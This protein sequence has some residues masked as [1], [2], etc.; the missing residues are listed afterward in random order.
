[1]YVDIIQ[2]DAELCGDR[3]LQNIETEVTSCVR[4]R[5]DKFREH[6]SSHHLV[7]STREDKVHIDLDF[8]DSHSTFPREYRNSDDTR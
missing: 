3:R 2:T 4:Y 5:G 1:M 7:L 6:T 8:P